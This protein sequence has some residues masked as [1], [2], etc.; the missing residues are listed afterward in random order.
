[1]FKSV[2][3]ISSLHLCPD[4]ILTRNAYCFPKHPGLDS[5][6]CGHSNAISLHITTLVNPST[7]LFVSFIRLK[8][9]WA[10]PT[11]DAQKAYEID[12]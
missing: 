1:M 4:A 6:K 11:A 3:D 5:N 10:G 7:D 2:H 9:L 8:G 12:G